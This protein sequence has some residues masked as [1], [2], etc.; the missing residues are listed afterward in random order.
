MT[1]AH[2]TPQHTGSCETCETG[3]SCRGGIDPQCE[4]FGCWGIPNDAPRCSAYETRRREMYASLGLALP[5]VA[6]AH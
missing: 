2:T 6:I 4:H 1:D 3:C 5:P